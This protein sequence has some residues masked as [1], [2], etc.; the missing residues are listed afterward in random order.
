MAYIRLLYLE[1]SIDMHTAAGLYIETEPC[2]KKRFGESDRQTERTSTK[3]RHFRV[4]LANDVN[5]SFLY[6]GCC[7]FGTMYERALRRGR[8]ENGTKN[9]KKRYLRETKTSF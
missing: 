3:K 9:T 7:L 8:Q 6:L 2:T 4:A 1:A 5:I